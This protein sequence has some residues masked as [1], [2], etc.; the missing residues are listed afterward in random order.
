MIHLD[1]NNQTKE[2]KMIDKFVITVKCPVENKDIHFD[3]SYLEN[4]HKWI[5]SDR[6]IA[7]GSSLMYEAH[8]LQDAVKDILSIAPAEVK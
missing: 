1:F 6:R 2:K 4:K 3:F 7:S 8:N 5:V